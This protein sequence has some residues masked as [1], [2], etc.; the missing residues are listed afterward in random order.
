M[1]NADDLVKTNKDIDEWMSIAAE[2]K[3]KFPVLFEALLAKIGLDENPEEEINRLNRAYEDGEPR[4]KQLIREI[5]DLCLEGFRDTMKRVDVTYDSWDWGKRL[6][7][8]RA[9]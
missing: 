7:L 8:E 2:L 4:A 9:G 1:H 5:S 6:R 3:E